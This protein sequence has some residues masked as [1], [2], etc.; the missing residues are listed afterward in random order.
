MR[1]T[2]VAKQRL[3]LVILA[4]LILATIV[5]SMGLGAAKVSYDRILPTLFGYG[6]FKEEFVL[7]SIRM[8]RIVITL[9]A[10]MALALSGSLL[11]GVTRN[12]LADPGVIG[13]NAGAGVG[14]AVFFLFFPIEPGSFVYMIPVVAFLGAMI[15]T[16]LIYLF[17]YSR[18]NGLQPIAIVLNGIGF[19][20]A[21]SGLMYVLI[22][23]AEREKVDFI[24]KWLAG[25]IWG[26]D[27]PFVYALLPWLVVL[28]PF[29][30][31]KA[32]RL[33]ILG[34]SD[35]VVIGVGVSMNRERT[36]LL[37]A[38]VALAAAAVSVA[39]GITFIGLMAP[40]IARALVGPRFQLFMP[41]SILIGGFLLLVADTIGRNIGSAEGVAAGIIVALIGGPYFVYLLMRKDKAAG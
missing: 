16:L 27:W 20:F 21:L 37:L 35:P 9:L 5:I 18:K 25:N 23:S 1:P 30:L 34:L 14:V 7:R 31:Y 36:W 19:A 3:I 38:A 17:S 41:V 24:S 40:H 12:E 10:G 8:P 32:N 6:T 22:S 28:V 11:Q 15:T 26:T 29:A 4:A 2:V 13:I 33:N 39:G